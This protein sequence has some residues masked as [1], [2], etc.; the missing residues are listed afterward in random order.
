[1]S[2]P[3]AAFL[4]DAFTASA[5][6]GFSISATRSTTETFGVG[7]RMDRPCILPFS[8]GRTKPTA[9][10]APVLVGIMDMAAARARRRSLWG[11]SRI[12]WSLVYEWIVVI[13]PCLI[14]KFCRSTLTTGARQLVVQE[15]L[16]MTWCLA[17]S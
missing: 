8:S 7:T 5:V 2:S 17:G 3:S 10:A 9:F 15:A 16:E 11:R 13:R 14:P 1:M 4:R 6:T 12:C